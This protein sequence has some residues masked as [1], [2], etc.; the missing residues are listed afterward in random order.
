MN[1]TTAPYKAATRGDDTP[2]TITASSPPFGR[3]PVAV[4]EVCKLTYFCSQGNIHANT[5]GYKFIGALLVARYRS[6]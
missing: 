5:Q 3:V 1:V 6:L 2:L 4:A